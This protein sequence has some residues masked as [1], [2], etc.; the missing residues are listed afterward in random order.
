M[1]NLALIPDIRGKELALAFNC[2][3]CLSKTL[4]TWEPQAYQKDIKLI[5]PEWG[6]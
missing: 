6:T 3:V 4:V 5:T 1:G 2:T